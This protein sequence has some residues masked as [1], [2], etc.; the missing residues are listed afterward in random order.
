MGPNIFWNKYDN[1]VVICASHNKWH[2]GISFQWEHW[3][4]PG[5]SSAQFWIPSSKV[6]FVRVSFTYCCIS[7]LLHV[8]PGLWDWHAFEQIGNPST[9][10]MLCYKF[11]GKKTKSTMAKT[12]KTMFLTDNKFQSE[13]KKEWASSY[14]QA[15]TLLEN[16]VY[17]E[18]QFQA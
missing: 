3:E 2:S 14:T 4:G 7:K 18:R 13:W 16:A 11:C 10:R 5:S 6:C 1:V 15:P 12:T 9:K 8:Y 17:N